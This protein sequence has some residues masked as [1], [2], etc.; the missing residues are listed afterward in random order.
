MASDLDQVNLKDYNQ[1]KGVKKYRGF[2]NKQFGKSGRDVGQIYRSTASDTLGEQQRMGDIGISQSLARGFGF[3]QP[4]GLSAELK[5][6]N[7]LEQDY[8]G[9]ALASKEA[10]RRTKLQMGQAMQGSLQSGANYVSSVNSPWLQE[11]GLMAQMAAGEAAAEGQED[12][13]TASSIG[14]I[15]SILSLLL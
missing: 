7:S 12:A 5:R 15:V 14:S 1:N 3:N 10:A 4:T 6:R 8:A 11:Q 9:A 2:L 13:A